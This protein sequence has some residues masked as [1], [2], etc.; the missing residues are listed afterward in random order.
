M[1]KSPNS[2]HDMTHRADIESQEWTQEGICAFETLGIYLAA[3]FS[4]LRLKFNLPVYLRLSM[5]NSTIRHLN[6]DP[7]IWTTAKEGLCGNKWIRLVNGL[8]V[9]NFRVDLELMEKGPWRRFLG[10]FMHTYL[11]QATM[12]C[13][14]EVPTA[15]WHSSNI[16]SNFE[17]FISYI[18]FFTFT[19]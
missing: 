11:L 7:M 17:S 16:L 3:P 4:I 6:R 15:V 8:A 14:D 19:P 5:P 1:T 10:L 12:S 2:I 9:P 18:F 13:W